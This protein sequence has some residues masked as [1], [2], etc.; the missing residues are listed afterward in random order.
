MRVACGRHE[1]GGQPRALAVAMAGT[2]CG[3]VGPCGI[4]I[5]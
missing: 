3:R 4:E 5:N 2:E 1:G